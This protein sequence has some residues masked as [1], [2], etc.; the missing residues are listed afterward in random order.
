[1]S[2]PAQ[3]VSAVTATRSSRAASARQQRVHQLGTG[4]VAQPCQ[5]C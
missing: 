3:A 4:F 1:M 5:H 2:S